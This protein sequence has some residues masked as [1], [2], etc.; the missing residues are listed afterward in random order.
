MNDL[1]TTSRREAEAC[2][3]AAQNAGL[4]RVRLGNEHLLI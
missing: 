2:L 4:T 1:P 3:D